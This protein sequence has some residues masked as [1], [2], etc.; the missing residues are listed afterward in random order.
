MIETSGVANNLDSI[1][2]EIKSVDAALYS[3]SEYDG[4][5]PECGKAEAFNIH[6]VNMAG[7]RKHKI[8][9]QVGINLY[10]GWRQESEERWKENADLLATFREIPITEAVYPE[11]EKN[12]RDLRA[13]IEG[14]RAEYEECFFREAE[15]AL[16]AT[17]QPLIWLEDT[18]RRHGHGSKSHLAKRMVTA[19]REQLE[20]VSVVLK[21]SGVPE[22][23]LPF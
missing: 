8:C 13:K 14:L 9:W 3:I 4:S 11:N 15:A 5:C 16:A 21:C 23:D 22:D 7:C 20:C 1:D 12:A 2:T 18:I 10:S 19:V 17:L 6:K